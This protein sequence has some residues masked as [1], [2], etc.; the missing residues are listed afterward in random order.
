MMTGINSSSTQASFP[1]SST[2]TAA[3]KIRVKNCCRN[4]AST[5]DMANCTRSMSLMMVESS[6]P[7]VCFWK[8]AGRAPQDGVVE[9]VAQIGDQ[10]EAGVVD[11]VGPG[12][13]EK[14]LQNGGGDECEGNHCPGILK[15][16]RDELL[17]IDDAIEYRNL[18]ELHGA[19]REPGSERGRR[20][21]R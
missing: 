12:V 19:G 1:P 14:S 20:S 8:K 13:I 2:T 17:Q 21:A 16:R 18:E 4:S 6:V 9:I 3:V 10:S 15:V 11:Q 5:L 7:V